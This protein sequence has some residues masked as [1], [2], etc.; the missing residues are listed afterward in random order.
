MC[1]SIINSKKLYVIFYNILILGLISACS[2]SEQ[3]FIED[4]TSKPDEVYIS[5]STS[6]INTDSNGGAFEV[7]VESNVNYEVVISESSKEWIH[8]E[9]KQE[10]KHTFFIDK[11]LEYDNREGIIIFKSKEL[12][13][14]IKVN[15]EG[16]SI[17]SLNE[18]PMR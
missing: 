7:E 11:S 1:K 9:N 16:S 12:S 6:S 18:I 4:E 17:L 3:D 14:T 5:L 10:N 8:E 15:Q 13:D 2:K